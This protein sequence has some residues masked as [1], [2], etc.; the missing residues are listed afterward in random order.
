MMKGVR[1]PISA[2]FCE[3]LTS[4]ERAGSLSRRPGA[5]AGLRAWRAAW[6]ARRWG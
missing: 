5:L 3:K 4:L 1:D 6:Q 2:Q